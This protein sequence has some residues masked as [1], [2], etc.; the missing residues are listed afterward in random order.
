MTEMQKIK[1]ILKLHMK[2]VSDLEDFAIEN[3]LLDKAKEY[4]A[5]RECLTTVLT[6]IKSVI[7]GF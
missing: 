4:T 7:K 1:H 6:D 3:G 5:Q 2:S